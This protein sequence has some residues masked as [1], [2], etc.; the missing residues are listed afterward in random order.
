MALA[1]ECKNYDINLWKESLVF[2]EVLLT[3]PPTT[4]KYFI[5]YTDCC[6]GITKQLRI[7]NQTG[8]ETLGDPYIYENTGFV[9]FL[10][11]YI[12]VQRITDGLSIILG[13]YLTD[14]GWVEISDIG[15]TIPSCSTTTI[16]TT[17]IVPTTTKNP[18]DII[19]NSCC[20]PGLTF[21]TRLTQF[22]A[23]QK[24]ICLKDPIKSVYLISGTNSQ[25]VNSASWSLYFS[26]ETATNPGP[27][28]SC[29]CVSQSVDCSRVR[30]VSSQEN[31]FRY[32]D[33]ESGF[34][35]DQMLLPRTFDIV[36]QP[37]LI[38]IPSTCSIAITSATQAV[39]FLVSQGTFVSGFSNGSASSI[40]YN[41]PYGSIMS[42][43]SSYHATVSGIYYIRSQIYGSFI[44]SAGST[45][46]INAKLQKDS[47]GVVSTID[48]Q[49]I[50]FT[51]S[52]PPASYTGTMSMLL[53]F[54]TYSLN[55]GDKVYVDI[56][57]SSGVIAA[58]Y[59]SVSCTFTQSLV[60]Y[61]T[62]SEN[63]PQSVNIIYNLGD[64]TTNIL[65]PRY[66]VKFGHPPGQT[67]WSGSTYSAP[68]TGGYTFSWNISGTISLYT[69]SNISQ[70][71]IS[72]I[73]ISSINGNFEYQEKIFTPVVGDQ[74]FTFSELS[75]QKNLTQGNVADLMIRVKI[76][77]L[78]N[79]FTD[80][81]LSLTYSVSDG[82]QFR[83]STAP[84]WETE[85]R[86]LTYFEVLLAPTYSS[87]VSAWG[88]D[89]CLR[90]P[91]ENRPPL[92][93]ISGS[94][95][96]SVCS[97]PGNVYFPACS[98]ALTFSCGSY[99]YSG[100]QISGTQCLWPTTTTSTTTDGGIVMTT[101]ATS[102]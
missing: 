56:S 40:S 86:D 45:N 26:N 65:G 69:A 55:A 49:N 36:E 13:T 78:Q 48:F 81:F 67:D 85:S 70:Y 68:L 10:P 101:T 66:L 25:L 76:R 72:V 51:F 50:I 59:T 83:I 16:T 39:N 7:D 92:E 87:S 53:G 79:V 54:Q 60:V 62:A 30:V 58:T 47:S 61:A 41:G 34:L 42:A 98:P 18:V 2:T 1:P 12:F 71:S 6:G 57:R 94:Y 52:S 96:Y 77:N 24:V 37:T 88:Y 31:V 27:S 97:T 80:A 4:W 28:C 89:F 19:F 11:P 99:T 64:P 20:D 22:F 73:P 5:G 43:S 82:S 17:T 29:S 90:N 75:Y 95:T 23:N 8:W 102:G 3:Y 63:T 15:S 35:N 93:R 14:D 32:I 100:V 46:S 91:I 74:A 9:S 38:S 21:S 84:R 44:F 33:C